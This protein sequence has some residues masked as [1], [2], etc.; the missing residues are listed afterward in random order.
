V[1]GLQVRVTYVDPKSDPEY[2]EVTQYALGRIAQ[3]SRLSGVKGVSFDPDDMEGTTL[4]MQL[5]AWAEMTRG[6]NLLGRPE[7]DDWIAAVSSVEFVKD[8]SVDPTQ[9]A[10]LDA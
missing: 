4:W 7:F 9:P 2:V 5:A 10:T 6:S 1:I 3:W 8:E